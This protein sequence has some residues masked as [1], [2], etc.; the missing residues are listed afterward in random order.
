[1]INNINIDNSKMT[2]EKFRFLAGPCVIESEDN[3]LFLAEAISKIADKHNV[4]F[5]F[6]ASWDKANRTKPTNYRG[7]GLD[8]GLKILQKV[9]DNVGVKIVTDIHEPHQA[10][11]VAQVADMLQI[12]SFHVPPAGG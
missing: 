6:K 9:K 10:A 12:P 2:N 11:P 4:D 8:E 7:P 3:V 5:F 1:M